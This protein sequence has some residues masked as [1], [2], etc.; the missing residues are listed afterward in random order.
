[1]N[2]PYFTKKMIWELITDFAC[3]QGCWGRLAK[4]I[5][6]AGEEGVAYLQ[7]LED[8]HFTDSL[9]VILYLEGNSC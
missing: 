7:S 4:Q 6:D 3:S 9:D 8:M 2:R 5:I 1:M